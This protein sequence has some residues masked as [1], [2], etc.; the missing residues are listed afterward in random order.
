MKLTKSLI[1]ADIIAAN[2]AYEVISNWL[3]AI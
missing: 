3:E 1:K 2:Q